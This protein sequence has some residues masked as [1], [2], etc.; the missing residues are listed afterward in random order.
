MARRS[1][2]APVA[3]DDGAAAEAPAGALDQSSLAHLLGYRLV[4]ADIA[5]RAVFQ[6]H[7]G[8]PLGLRPVEFTIL[9]LIASNRGCTGKQL[10]QALAVTAPNVT[11]LLDR[12]SEKGLVERV[13]GEADRRAQHVHL[14][15]EGER[16]AA[17]ALAVSRKME[18]DLLRRLT[19]GERLMLLE[20][21]HKVAR[22]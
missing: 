12:L 8:E 21:L 19:E 13:R 1:A 22:G 4:Q 18:R 15:G 16:L 11:I 9:V 10:A 6:R 17:E 20:L 3:G 7:I 14:T 5:T 2:P